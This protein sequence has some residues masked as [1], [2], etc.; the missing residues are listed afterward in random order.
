V[1]GVAALVIGAHGGQ[2]NPEVVEA[3]LR[4]TADDLGKPGVDDFYGHGR[5]NAAKAVG[6]P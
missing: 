3:V 5:V 6:A 1:A 2:M 4:T